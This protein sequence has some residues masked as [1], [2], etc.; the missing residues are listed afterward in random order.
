MRFPHLAWAIA[1]RGLP[2][3]KFAAMIGL[4]EARLSRC[5]AGRGEFTADERVSISRTLGFFESWLF[6]E[7]TLPAADCTQ[8]VHSPGMPA[9]MSGRGRGREG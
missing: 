9:R 3:Y 5:L 6:A 8:T 7:V 1:D 4:S 2:Q